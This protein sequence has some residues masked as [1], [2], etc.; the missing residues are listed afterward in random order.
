MCVEK[1]AAA[2]AQGLLEHGLI[3][4]RSWYEGRAVKD[5]QKLDRSEQG[6]PH[7]TH[8]REASHYERPLTTKIANSITDTG[9]SS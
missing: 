9:D 2:V 7:I 4:L 5:S 3:H 1:V 8:G 6:R